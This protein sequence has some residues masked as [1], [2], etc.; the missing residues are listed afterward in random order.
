LRS[1]F[2]RVFIKSIPT[3][4]QFARIVKSGWPQQLEGI[5]D[6]NVVEKAGF[7]YDIRAKSSATIAREKEL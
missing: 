6:V 3:L 4:S 2:P 5:D 7:G 1:S